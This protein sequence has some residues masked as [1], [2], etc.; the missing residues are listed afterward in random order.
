[1]SAVVLVESEK[2]KKEKVKEGA[3][4]HAP[5]GECGGCWQRCTRWYSC[6][7]ADACCERWWEGNGE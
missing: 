1:M 2:A 7:Y 4:P 5:Y 6:P 3:A